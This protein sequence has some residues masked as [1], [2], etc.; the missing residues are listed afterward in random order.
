MSEVATS[1]RMSQSS[2]KGTGSPQLPSDKRLNMQAR[3]EFGFELLLN[4]RCRVTPLVRQYTNI[5][6]LI[7]WSD[8]GFPHVQ[9]HVPQSYLCRHFFG[10][11]G[12]D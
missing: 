3:L 2:E 12:T 1:S 8:I 11:L 9:R 7:T 4:V 10:S 5:A 6:V